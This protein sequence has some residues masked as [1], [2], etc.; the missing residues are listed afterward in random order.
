MSESNQ[1]DSKTIEKLNK[2]IDD[3]QCVVRT[4]IILI[5]LIIVTQLS[6]ILENPSYGS[7]GLW[8][9]ITVVFFILAAISIICTSGNQKIIKSPK[10]I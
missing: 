3:V 5:I 2:K 9:S 1:E 7:S 10:Q 6:L 8:I 4:I